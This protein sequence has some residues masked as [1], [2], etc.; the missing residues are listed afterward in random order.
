MVNNCVV[1]AAATDDDDD[2]GVDRNRESTMGDIKMKSEW[3]EEKENESE[4]GN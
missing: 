3:G 2:D 1:A 4:R